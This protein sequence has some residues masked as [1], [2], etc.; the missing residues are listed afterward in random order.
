MLYVEWV[1]VGLHFTKWFQMM[2]K[3]TGFSQ[4]RAIM[5]NIEIYNK[6][7]VRKTAGVK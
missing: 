1:E 3:V 5:N 7:E 4:E 2:N 6:L